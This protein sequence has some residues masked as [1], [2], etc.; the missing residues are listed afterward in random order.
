MLSN[1]MCK[2]G[3][4]YSGYLAIVQIY[5]YQDLCNYWQ[6]GNTRGKPLGLPP[7]SSGR[8][9]TLLLIIFK[10]LLPCNIFSKVSFSSSSSSS[11]ILSSSKVH[12]ASHLGEKMPKAFVSFFCD[13]N[14]YLWYLH[15]PAT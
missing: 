7:F 1:Y 9:S 3:Q 4:F 2:E 5:W 10:S 12:F 13:K 11:L 14:F 15:S 6:I 8:L